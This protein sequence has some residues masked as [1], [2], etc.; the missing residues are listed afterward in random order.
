VACPVT[1]YLMSNWL[2]SFAY[3]IE[4]GPSQF[5][6]GGAIALTISL[7]T[8]SWQTIRAAMGNPVEAL[9]YE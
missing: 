4:L 9:R 6:V 3:R 1:Y 8:V 2:E 7:G 5:F